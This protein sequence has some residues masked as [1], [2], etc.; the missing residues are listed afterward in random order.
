MVIFS[1]TLFLQIIVL[2]G[3][4]HLDLRPANVFIKQNSDK[5]HAQCPTSASISNSSDRGNGSG[6]SVCDLLVAETYVLKLG[7]LGHVCLSEDTNWIEGE[8]R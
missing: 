7:D 6:K 3:M 1:L 8:S 5:S 2:S 4:A